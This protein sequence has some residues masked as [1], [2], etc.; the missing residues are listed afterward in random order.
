MKSGQI[1]LH[2]D[3]LANGY[4]EEPGQ[5]SIINAGITCKGGYINI[6]SMIESINLYESIFKTFITGDITLIDRSN[7][8]SN[9]TGTE[10]VYLEFSTKGSIYPVK[11]SLIV[12]KI[13]NKEKVNLNTTR[14]TLSMVSP[15]FLN[16]IRTK[17]SKSFEGNYSDMVK[18][19]YADY[20]SNGVPLWLENVNNHNRV[21]I[22]NKSPAD[23]INMIAQ[24]A[25]S[26]S[27]SNPD[28]LFYQT[29]KS[30]NFRSVVDM[31][32]NDEVKPEGITFRIEKEEI[33]P[34]MPIVKKATR[35]MEFKVLGQVDIIKHT[36]IG[37]YGATLISHDLIN[38]TWTENK[39]SYHDQFNE[40][41]NDFKTIERYPITP[42]GPV[43]PDG[44][45][46]S[47]F[48]N[49][50]I[51][52]LSTSGN[53]QYQ[54]P[55]KGSNSKPIKEFQK[56]DYRAS[57]LERNGE[58]NSLNLQRAKLIV[59]GMSGLQAGDIIEIE[60]HDL[61]EINKALSGK[62]LIE[63]LSHQIGDKY[64]CVLII[65]RNSVSGEQNKYTELDYPDLS[66]DIIE[67]SSQGSSNK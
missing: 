23:A 57:V 61:L 33:S 67:S 58:I 50:F 25:I 1:T 10:P 27:A 54:T 7:F 9:I 19:I 65:I 39:W 21:I 52:M 59:G 60:Y 28:F 30:F 4:L 47:G 34:N 49:S 48:P 15:E 3:L 6:A 29:T 53:H 32:L 24:F 41:H 17:L 2:E 37:T 56:L 55:T 18:H 12:S 14:Y 22:P 45:N 8:V 16:N 40:D 62:W 20:I 35:A 31:I 63:S 42:D 44:D 51:N 46:L 64:Y 43:T 38:K 5:F 11:L 26:S 36:A 13:K 66:Y